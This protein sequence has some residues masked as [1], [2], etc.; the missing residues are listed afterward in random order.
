MLTVC[1]VSTLEFQ[2]INM[3]S[4]LIFYRVKTASV[5]YTTWRLTFYYNLNTYFKNI[6]KL[7]TTVKAIE[8]LCEGQTE[9]LTC[10]STIGLLKEHLMNTQL[11]TERV[12]SFDVKNRHKR[13]APLGWIGKGMGVVYGLATVDDIDE[14]NRRIL[15]VETHTLSEKDSLGNQ[16]MV[17]EQNV[18]MNNETF[19]IMRKYIE[20]FAITVQKQQ[21]KN[22]LVDNIQ[23]LHSLA[24]SI[25]A[26]HTETYNDIMDLL[27]NSLNGKVLKMISQNTLRKCLEEISKTLNADQEL[28]VNL[29]IQSPL[30]IFLVSEV[31]GI[32]ESKRILINLRIP[33]VTKDEYKLYKTIPIPMKINNSIYEIEPSS[34]YFLFETRKHYL[35]PISNTELAECRHSFNDRLICS[36]ESPSYSRAKVSCELSMLTDRDAGEISSVCNMKELVVRNYIIPLYYNNTYY[37]VIPE[38]MKIRDN[39]DSKPNT[40]L[41]TNGIIYGIPGCTI[42]TGE[43]RIHVPQTINDDKERILEPLLCLDSISDYHI[44]LMMNNWNKTLLDTLTVIPLTDTQRRMTKIIDAIALERN[45][46]SKRKDLLEQIKQQQ[47]DQYPW[48]MKAGYYGVFIL[49]IMIV[50]IKLIQPII[51]LFLKK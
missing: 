3:T 25:I 9:I 27:Q 24:N 38:Q 21:K 13:W 30:N 35:I 5:S 33:I 32:L 17:L 14:I 51:D 8:E 41:K 48:F 1:S 4:G 43:L 11:D 50:Y 45:E 34:E 7:K 23:Y 46:I 10:N 15:A 49:A 29:K 6:D 28:P 47:E 22:N 12:E 26:A 19:N 2:E 20:D 44:E 37:C 39:C 42:V 31:E 40:I 36:P 16:L 18:R